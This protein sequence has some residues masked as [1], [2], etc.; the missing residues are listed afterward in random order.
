[1]PDETLYGRLG[2]YDAIRAVV[3]DFYDRLLDDE[4]LAPFF[5]DADVERLRR[6][7]TAFLCEAAGGPETYDAEPVREA[8]LHVPF[9]EDHIER[10]VGHLSDSLDAFDVPESDAEEV[11]GAV[12]A[13]RE[14][15]LD[16]PADGG[17]E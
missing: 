15:L 1:M 7:Q 10:A 9:T 11:V 2:G 6:T 4:E 13:H 5:E 17:A 16:R 3:D 14:E 8:H 12:A